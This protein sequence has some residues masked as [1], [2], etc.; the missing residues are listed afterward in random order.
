MQVIPGLAGNFVLEKKIERH[1]CWSNL[2]LE[3][4]KLITQLGV[5]LLNWVTKYPVLAK[6]K[7]GV[8]NI[9]LLEISLWAAE[10][11]IGLMHL[12]LV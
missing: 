8:K 12:D 6:E 7:V 4:K 2:I 10:S 11:L 3:L 5:G 1:W 9:P